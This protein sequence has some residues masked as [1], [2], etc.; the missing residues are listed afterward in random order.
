MPHYTLGLNIFHA[1]SSSCLMKDGKLICAFEEERLNRIKHWA[2]VP[3]LSI[4]ECLKHAE[5]KIDDINI[6]TINSNPYSNLKNKF[7]YTVNSKNIFFN[8]NSFLKRQSKKYSIIREI[9]KFFKRKIKAKLLRYDHHLSHIASSYY[10][11]GFK[12]ATGI[13]ID[14][15]GDFCSLAISRCKGKNIK[16]LARTFYPNSLGVFYEGITQILGFE[17]YGDEY[18]VMGLSA[19]GKPIYQSKLENLINYD[20]KKLIYLN[21]N[22]FLHTKKGFK[23]TFDGL[24]KISKLIDKR[25]FLKLLNISLRD[26]ENIKVKANIASSAQKIYEKIFF[27]IIDKSLNYNKSRNLVLS[28][29]CVMNCLANGKL[30]KHKVYKK[31]FIPYCPGDNGGAIGSA[32]LSYNKKIDLKSFQNPYTGIRSNN[33]NELNNLIKKNKFLFVKFKNY[34]DLNK[35]MVQE[36]VKKKIIAILRNN[37]E[38]GSRALGNTSIIC[39]P[40]LSN[41]KKILNSKIKLREKFRPFAPAILDKSVSKWFEGYIKSPYMSFVLKFRKNKKKLVPAVCHYDETGRIQTV[42]KNQNPFFYDLIRV[43]EKKTKIPI[44]LNTSFNENEP[45]VESQKRAIETFKRTSID[46]LNIDKYLIFKNER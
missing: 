46:F 18:K 29:G 14:G 28:G 30:T 7:L 8:I 11:S 15:F 39:D 25:K 2:G 1:D 34:N 16:V 5:I 19:Y 27:R 6:I 35:K 26:L 23:Y 41:A 42:S 40:R 20:E 13:S 37:M 32:L 10:L 44:L 36:L 24:P 45:I 12:E 9:E 17:N 33:E 43:F 4:N 3:L 38:F 21:L 22:Y 31:I